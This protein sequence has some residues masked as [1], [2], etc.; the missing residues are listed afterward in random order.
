MIS[1]RQEGDF[2]IVEIDRPAKRNALTNAML[3]ALLEGVTDLVDRDVSVLIVRS[4]SEHFSAGADLTEWAEP[5][6]SEAAR[7]SRLGNAAFD[8]IAHAPMPSIAAIDGVAAGGGLELALA[9]DLRVATTRARLGLPETGLGNVPAYGG[10][11]RLVQTV[12]VAYARELLFTAE[13]VDA[14]RAAEIGLVNRLV[15]PADLEG[16][17]DALARRIADGDPHAISLAKAL[18]GGTRSDGPLA[19]VTSQA[20]ESR[21]RKNNFLDRRP[22]ASA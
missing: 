8:A 14:R 21:R 7:M 18:T 17:V 13:L 3:E 9:C 1:I 4:T 22:A 5:T 10:M 19:A 2:G 11:P 15:E 20:P 16:A 6:A 12:G